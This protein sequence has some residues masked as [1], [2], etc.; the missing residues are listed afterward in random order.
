MYEI[1]QPLLE[2]VGKSVE[3]WSW[4]DQLPET[5]ASVAEDW[6]LR[7]GAPIGTE[8]SCSWVAPCETPDG[9]HAVLKVGFPHM[10]SR[11]EIPGLAFWD[12]DP[13][14]RLLD[15]DSKR[16]A[17]LL[18]RC[19]PGTAL[20]QED[21]DVQDV[22]IAELLR[23]LW[24]PPPNDHGF[25]P[26]AEMI[27]SWALDVCHTSSDKGLVETAL[28]AAR[29]LADSVVEPVLLATDLHAGNVLRAKRRPW[30]AID[31]KPFVGDRCYDGTQHLFNCRARMAREPAETSRRLAEL[32]EVDEVRF[33]SWVFIR[34]ALNVDEDA[35]ATARIAAQLR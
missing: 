20:R 4:L 25:R 30:L 19:I 5:I 23:R 22:V 15:A 35:E 28:D 9:E 10:E 11:D 1:P 3:G 13:T 32:L 16:N 34:F 6:S 27:E 7:L 17:M 18:E 12:G 8:A 14:V 31:P 29:E 24:R 21:E 26:L 33:R 2:A